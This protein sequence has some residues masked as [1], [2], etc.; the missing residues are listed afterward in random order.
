MALS[1][2]IKN[3]MANCENSFFE[4]KIFI[5]ANGHLSSGHFCFVHPGIATESALGASDARK[6][7]N[8]NSWK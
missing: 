1:L 4:R 2:F 5:A 8:L 3:S 7:E 6:D